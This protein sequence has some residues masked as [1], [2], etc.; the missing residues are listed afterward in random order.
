MTEDPRVELTMSEGRKSGKKKVTLRLS[1]MFGMSGRPSGRNSQRDDA[2][3][4][5]EISEYLESD[6]VSG[7]ESSKML[8]MRSNRTGMGKPK[9]SSRWSIKQVDIAVSH[10]E[11]RLLP[12]RQG[13]TSDLNAF[14]KYLKELKEDVVRSPDDPP[15]NEDFWKKVRETLEIATPTGFDELKAGEFQIKSMADTMELSAKTP[16][17]S[18]SSHVNRLGSRR[19]L[20]C[21]TKLSSEKCSMPPP[22]V[23]LTWS[24]LQSVNVVAV[25]SPRVRTL[26]RL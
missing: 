15:F 18:I 24:G 11:A 6:I 4:E 13:F 2:P 12:C 8:R 20:R 26:A 5:T 21:H 17:I 16:S 25:P 14:D 3:I 1:R 23:W 9:L 10:N 7:G 19:S 22:L